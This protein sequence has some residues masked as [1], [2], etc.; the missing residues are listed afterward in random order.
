MTEGG[1]PPRPGSIEFEPTVTPLPAPPPGPGTGDLTAVLRSGTDGTPVVAS[2]PS[3]D[4]YRRHARLGSG[5]MGEVFAAED[6]LIGRE[7]AV[8]SMTIAPSA[9]LTERFLR[10]ARIQGALEHPAIVPVHDLG[11]DDAG[12]PYFV[13][14]R[15]GG[16]TLR[17]VLDGAPGAERFGRRRQLEALVDVCQAVQLAHERGV[18]HRDLKPSNVMLGAHGEVYVLDWG[19]ARAGG[20]DGKWRD[21]GSL[22]GSNAG[23]HA[24]GTQ[25]G[26]ILGTP[27]YMPPEQAR[28]EVVDARADV[29]A[30]GAILF[31][32][33][34]GRSF[35]DRGVLDPGNIERSPG[36]RVPTAEV[37]PEL[38][39]VCVQALAR[40]RDE[41][42]PSARALAD[43]LQR[44]LDGDRDLA[45][46][47]EL[48]AEQLGAAREALARHDHPAALAAAG[49]ALALDPTSTDAAELV[50]HLMLAPPTALPPEVVAE[51][52]AQDAAAL[53]LGAR[54]AI[55]TYASYFLGLPLLYWH[56]VSRWDLILVIYAFITLGLVD[57]WRVLRL[58]HVS[59]RRI[60]LSYVIN[61]AQIGSLAA[62]M[63]PLVIVPASLSVIVIF[64]GNFT[65]MRSALA[66]GLVG[67]LSVAVPVML[68]RFGWIPTTT[69]F[70]VGEI[71]LRSEVIRISPAATAG[72]FVVHAVML[73]II[74]ATTAQE[75]AAAAR[76]LREEQAL[77]AWRLRQL[78]PSKEA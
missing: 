60:W 1:R 16:L 29:Y 42:L 30:L 53:H 78:V 40:E 5:A 77:R 49:R 17:E 10:E 47:R 20:D 46:R 21:V 27:G 34:A 44:Y 74:V 15:L 33:L 67:S 28:G 73:A 14:K 32:I 55:A 72:F 68:E 66:L 6:R 3:G 70:G 8:K 41:R 11:V 71:T 57:A 9:D 38:D 76:R 23:A 35:A 63:G 4:R 19:I 54:R 61:V 56:G 22:S 50:S 51:V 59:S 24:G 52:D 25:V 37:P 69:S 39:R 31:E 75:N 26:T 65:R 36:R 7:V 48:A 13:M 62:V 18:V 43:E 58:R 64:Y 45:R 12:R 2:L